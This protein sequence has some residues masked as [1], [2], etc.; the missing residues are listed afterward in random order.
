VRNDRRRYRRRRHLQ[1][2]SRGVVSVVGTLL[3]LLVFFA[4]FGIFLTEYVP[5]WMTENES[6]WS[7]AAQ[8]SMAQLQSS[9][10]QQ[11][12]FGSPPTYA[13]TF[14]LQSQGIPLFAQGTQGSLTFLGA[15]YYSTLNLSTHPGY[16][17]T[18]FVFLKIA[19]PGVAKPLWANYSTGFVSMNLPNRYYSAQTIQL[20][21]DAVI[22]S[23]TATNQYVA[24]PPFI[25]LTQTSGNFS[26]AMEVTQ[27]TGNST[28]SSYAGTQDMYSHLI[29]AAPVTFNNSS[30]VAGFTGG[31]TITMGVYTHFPCAWWGLFNQTVSRAGL[32]SPVVATIANSGCVSQTSAM[33]PVS[34]TL[35][36]VTSFS[37]IRGEVRMTTGVGAS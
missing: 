3:S 27:L 12:A 28:S 19:Y 8:T 22:V 25:S 24:Y 23:Q 10:E 36:D 6:Q 35:T 20:E 13:T 26:V 1:R 32:V 14:N 2:D 37:Y 9:L 31:L 30:A 16:Q 33:V 21:D 15:A 17:E 11:I 34:L 4:L 18:P 5:V 7:T 29:G